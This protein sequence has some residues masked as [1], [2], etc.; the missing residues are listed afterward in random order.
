ML[1]VLK[2]KKETGPLKNLRPVNLLSSIR[3]TF[4][5]ITLNRMKDKVD[6]YLPVSQTAYRWV[7]STGDIIS[8]HKIIAVKAQTNQDLKVHMT[9]NAEL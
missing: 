1:P 8:T 2:A 7:N 9:G 4:S 3:K 6:D 5:I